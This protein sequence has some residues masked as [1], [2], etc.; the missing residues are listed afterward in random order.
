M[1]N[2]EKARG[3]FVDMKQC[4]FFDKKE[5]VHK[6]YEFYWF[7]QSCDKDGSIELRAITFDICLYIVSKPKKFVGGGS[8]LLPVFGMNPTK[9]TKKQVDRLVKEIN[10]DYSELRYES[11]RGEDTGDELYWSESEH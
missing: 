11:E 6:L 4:S 5:C 8:L 10:S 9:F 1:S 3:L 2:I 7:F